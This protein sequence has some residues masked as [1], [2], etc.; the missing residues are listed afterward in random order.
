MEVFSDDSDIE[1][2][3]NKDSKEEF[4]FK[5]KASN[6]EYEVGKGGIIYQKEYST[7]LVKGKNVMLLQVKGAYAQI[8]FE[9]IT[10]ILEVKDL[11][12]TDKV[13]K[14]KS[15]KL[16]SCIT[17]TN[18]QFSKTDILKIV[19]ETDKQGNHMDQEPTHRKV[20]LDL[21]EAGN[22]YWVKLDIIPKEAIHPLRKLDSTHPQI[23]NESAGSSQNHG[24]IEYRNVKKSTSETTNSETNYSVSPCWCQLLE[25][26]E[27]YYTKEPTPEFLKGETLKQVLDIE[28]IL[29]K[30]TTQDKQHWCHVSGMTFEG[31]KKVVKKGW[32]KKDDIKEINAA[33]WGSVGWQA[34][35]ETGDQYIYQ[36]DA[37]NGESAPSFIEKIWDEIEKLPVYRTSK[38]GG[39]KEVKQDRILSQFELQNA[40]RYEKTVNT[41]SKL[42]CC[43]PS[44][45]D[46]LKSKEPFHKE[47]KTLYEKAIASESD[48]TRKQKIEDIRDERWVQIEE[49][50]ANLCFWDKV[51]SGAVANTNKNLPARFFPKDSKVWH[52]HPIAFVEQMQRINP[53]LSF[54]LRKIPYNHPNNFKDNR[55]KAYDYT[56]PSSIAAPFGVVRG[57]NRIHA[58]CDLYGDPGDD[59]LAVADGK[60]IS[61]TKYYN[62]TYQITIRH[63]FEIKKG[64]K[65]IVRYGEVHKNNIKVKVPDK[66]TKGQKIAEIGLLIPKIEQPSGDARGMLHFEMYTGECKG[67]SVSGSAGYTEMLYSESDDPTMTCKSKNNSNRRYNR[68]KDLINPLYYLNEMIKDL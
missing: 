61:V 31:T 22:R 34:F 63:D 10:M 50:L 55:Y 13:A 25:T 33:D 9:N 48:S 16:D 4:F 7:N 18:Y 38:G 3:S 36:F 68:R 64:V 8:G 56:L 59:V 54:P 23:L 2:I 11:D 6:L 35:K 42:I 62:D 19:D 14:I 60:V 32:V 45:W 28:T 57:G 58:A 12:V 44:E 30:R 47:V 20:V 52:F 24:N 37:N 27:W 17:G 41:L 49:K 46:L 1:K 39:V 26:P 66:V 65:M 67:D 40:L 51:K 5:R 29:E 21:K 43:H 15:D 53:K